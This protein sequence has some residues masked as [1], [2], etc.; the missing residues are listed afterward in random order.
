MADLSLNR[1]LWD[2]AGKAGAVLG[3]V[4]IA[5]LVITTFMAGKGGVLGG[6][7]GAVLALL[8][9]G[10]KFAACIYLM[11]FFML[12]YC[13]GDSEATSRETFRFGRR[14]ALLSAL[15][16]SAF[17]LAFYTLIAPD[18]LASNLD[19]VISSYSSMLDSNALNQL[20]QLQ[21]DLPRWM[22]F[23]NLIYCYLFGTLVS[24]FLSRNIP[25]SDPFDNPNR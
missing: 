3:A 4:S 14:T 5:Y 24:F 21:N 9:W 6:I 20:E 22:F 7:G 10:V 13:A 2:S 18:A 19:M 17:V 25:S 12:R 8:L 23:S 1:K 11:K 16:Y 15:L